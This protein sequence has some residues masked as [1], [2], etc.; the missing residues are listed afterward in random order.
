MEIFDRV[1]KEI[2]G[3]RLLREDGL[4]TCIPWLGLPKFS[5]VVPGIE[6]ARYSGVTAN[7]KVGK[8]QLADYMFMY[9]PLDFI[10]NHRSNI[11]I[12]L[13]YFSL[14]ISKSAKTLGV[15]SNKLYSK[16]GLKIDPQNLLSKFNNFILPKEHEDKIKGL[17]D[18]FEWFENHVTIIDDI[19]NPFGIYKYCRNWFEKNGTIH[20]KTISINGEDH[21]IMDYYEP[22]D[23]D[24]YTIIIVDNFNLL[25]AE[26]G[27]DLKSAIEKFSSDY[28]LTLRDK[29]GAHIVAIQQQAA[30]KENQEHNNKGGLLEQK[31][32]PSPDGLGDSKL[33]G[34]DMDYLYGLFSPNRFSIPKWAGYNIERLGDNHRELSLSLNR[35]GSGFT[36]VQLYFNGAVNHFSELED[37]SVIKYEKYVK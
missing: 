23:K 25:T 11:K 34:R 16:H 2:Q 33:S 29:F 19:R 15:I 10:S 21:K 24:L 1:F 12:R 6:K 28:A 30:A 36:S 4:Y 20:Y 27:G 8:T 18:Y 31:L 5:T 26:K 22:K 35:H 9:Q 13:L 14:E 37:S 17:E 7:S 3:N 32:R